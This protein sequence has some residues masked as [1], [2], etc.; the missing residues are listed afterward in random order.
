[1]NKEANLVLIIFQEN[2]KMGQ[3][4]NIDF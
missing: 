4:T 2:D 3:N 1:M